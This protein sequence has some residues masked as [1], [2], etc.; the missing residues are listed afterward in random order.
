MLSLAGVPNRWH[1]LVYFDGVHL[2]QHK[3]KK[4]PGQTKLGV[5]IKRRL[6]NKQ[7]PVSRCCFQRF[8]VIKQP[9]LVLTCFF[10]CYWACSKGPFLVLNV[11]DV[12]ISSFQDSD[13]I[14]FA[15]FIVNY[16]LYRY[17]NAEDFVIAQIMTVLFC[18]EQ[19][20][21]QYDFFLQP[22]KIL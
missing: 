12:Q 5:N 14:F 17:V 4:I 16:T 19:K 15:L 3:W 13:H 21:K 7:S 8:I 10:F 1:K 9:R 2:V 6:N 18:Q 22:C 11:N 20:L